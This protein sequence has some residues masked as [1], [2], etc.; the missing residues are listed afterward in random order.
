M[1]LV[2]YLEI[3]FNL[4]DGTY[5]PYTK[6]NNK[7][8]YLHKDINQP[9]VVTIREILVFIES[10]LTTLSYNEKIFQEALPP[11]HKVLQNSGIKHTFT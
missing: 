5:K 2:N 7:I 8:I 9:P 4:N 11:N 6:L 3:T 1:K 10:R